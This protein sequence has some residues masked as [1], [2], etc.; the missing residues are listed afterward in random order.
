MSSKRGTRRGSVRREDPT[1]S[2]GSSTFVLH[3]FTPRAMIPMSGRVHACTTRSST[4]VVYSQNCCNALLKQC[5][6]RRLSQEPDFPG[7]ETR[8]QRRLGSASLS[9]VRSPSRRP[10]TPDERQLHQSLREASVSVS[11]SP[12][13]GRRSSRLD[14]AR[15]TATPSPPIQHT[16]SSASTP[17]APTL[18]PAITTDESS[19]VVPQQ[20]KNNSSFWRYPRLPLLGSRANGTSPN[21]SSPQNQDPSDNESTIS[22]ITERHIHRDDL[23]R[24]KA[25]SYRE[26]L[27]GR[28]ITAPPRRLSGLTFANDTIHERPKSE[29]PVRQTAPARTL[30]S[31]TAV[32]DYADEDSAG[33]PTP[34]S[35][36]EQSFVFVD[37]PRRPAAFI[38]DTSRFKIDWTTII[39]ILVAIS[40][41]TLSYLG[42]Q[43]APVYPLNHRPGNYSGLNATEGRIVRQLS[44]EVDK[45]ESQLLSMSKDMQRIKTEKVVEHVTAIQPTTP[46]ITRRINFLSLGMGTVV[47]LSLTSP[48]IGPRKTLFR[49]L[50]E[51][52][53]GHQLPR[54]NPPEVALESWDDV[55]DC[56]CSASWKDGQAQLTVLLGQRAVPEEVVVEHLPAGA[57]PNPGVAPRDMELWAQF[58]P[59]HGHHTSAA[60]VTSEMPKTASH[61]GWFRPAFLKSKSTASSSSAVPDFVPSSRSSLLDVIMS[62]LHRAYPSEPETSFSNDPLLGPCFFRIGRWQYDRDGDA[63]Q[64]FPLDAVIDLPTLRVDKVIF[65]VTSNWGANHTCLYRL[66]MHGHL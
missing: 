28:N 5:T 41:L 47:D 6:G 18:N 3:R 66:K 32:Q 38:P 54:P 7:P 25:D 42:Y 62:I 52:I 16:I 9:P 8:L 15:S 34:P 37:R 12:S 57:S 11:G 26:E 61:S 27:Q 4:P 65:R 14:N 55:G 31:T 33:E 17:A 36:A 22:W 56:W 64:H 2:P 51:N 53:S 23:Q 43:F 60:P 10:A 19:P 39:T 45:L 1:Y 48:S 29:S 21:L 35:S 58:K 49:R 44:N 63:V 30:I 40:A 59:H 20:S 46:E 13:K 50:Y 24:T